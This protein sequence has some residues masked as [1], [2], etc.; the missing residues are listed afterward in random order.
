MDQN[1]ITQIL[2]KVK[3]DYTAIARVRQKIWSEEKSLIKYIKNNDTVLDLGCGQG[4][5]VPLLKNKKINY[6]GLDNC[7]SL[8]KNA[9]GL[10]PNY[11][12]INQDITKLDLPKKSFDKI[13]VIAILHHIPSKSLRLKILKNIKKL[14]KEGG[15]LLMTNWNLDDYQH[16]QKATELEKGDYYIPWRIKKEKVMRYY[17][18]FGK[19]ELDDLIKEAGLTIV[20]SQKNKRNLVI[21][22]KY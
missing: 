8:I 9:Q 10:Y 15:M 18:N 5:I 7:T 17:H 11:K 4:R 19:K 3:A 13:L 14:L 12:F 2:N 20:K 22:A 21:I 16:K 1:K 6:V